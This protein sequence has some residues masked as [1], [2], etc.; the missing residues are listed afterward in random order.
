MS[1]IAKAIAKRTMDAPCGVALFDRVR[2][3]W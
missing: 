1:S 2:G 3:D